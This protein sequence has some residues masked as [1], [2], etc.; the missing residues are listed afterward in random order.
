MPQR[1]PNAVARAWQRSAGSRKKHHGTAW[2]EAFA[3]GLPGP[4]T[5]HFVVK[6]WS[7]AWVV[8]GLALTNPSAADSGGAW[9]M[10]ESGECRYIPPDQWAKEKARADAAARKELGE[11]LRACQRGDGFSCSLLA[12]AYA[13][14]R[15][16][17][18]NAARARAYQVR[19]AQLW[20]KSCRRGAYDACAS[21]ADALES[22]EG[23]KKDLA[24]AQSTRRLAHRKMRDLCTNGDGDAC[25]SLG[26]QYILA[27]GVERSW[28]EQQRL[29]R[30]ADELRRSA[31][32]R[33]EWRACRSAAGQVGSG[34]G[35]PEDPAQAKVLHER[36][37]SLARAACARKDEEACAY[38]RR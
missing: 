12:S 33:G 30:R 25:H 22:G 26:T 27:A 18:P 8:A 16:T 17:K 2:L 10:L 13:D 36:A 1:T 37:V 35:V 15:G 32:A 20:A 38:L 7:V 24:R 4:A 28:D 23:V 21:L 34:D 29:Y 6:A 14:G 3:A 31:C 5:L 11:S 9:V 19:A